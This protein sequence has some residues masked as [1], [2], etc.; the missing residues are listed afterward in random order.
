MLVECKNDK[1]KVAMG[2]L[3]YLPDFKNLDNLKDEIQLNKNSDEF[4]LYLYRAKNP[5]FVGV[6]GTQWNNQF[7]VIRYLSLAP[8]YRG[9]KYEAQIVRELAANNPQKKI[10]AVPEYINLIKYL[11]Q[12]KNHE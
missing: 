5:N 10:T 6:V 11:A 7:I 2:L 9:E 4:Q 1:E 12:N 8:D 3:S